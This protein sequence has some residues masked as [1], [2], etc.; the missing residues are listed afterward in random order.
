[1]LFVYSRYDSAYRAGQRSVRKVTINVQVNV[2]GHHYRGEIWTKFPALVISNA[3]DVVYCTHISLYPLT[4]STTSCCHYPTVSRYNISYHTGLYCLPPAW[5][6]CYRHCITF[7]RR[8][9]HHTTCLQLTRNPSGLPLNASLLCRHMAVT[10]QLSAYHCILSPS[11]WWAWMRY[12]SILSTIASTLPSHCSTTGLQP[13][14]ID[15]YCTGIAMGS[16]AIVHRQLSVALRS[17][18]THRKSIK[19]IRV[20]GWHFGIRVCVVC[21]EW[22]S[23]RHGKD[24]H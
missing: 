5:T 3:W 23:Q 7:V 8:L 6:V 1:M 21:D 16:L 15:Q 10:T 13:I 14:N 22:D 9:Y 19:V 11:Y 2:A 18:S 4:P 24:V 12:P 17:S 20:V